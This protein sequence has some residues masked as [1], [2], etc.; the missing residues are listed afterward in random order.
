MLLSGLAVYRLSMLLYFLQRGDCFNGQ[1][2]IDFL[3]FIKLSV[4][5]LL[6]FLRMGGSLLQ[7]LLFLDLQ[8]LVLAR[9]VDQAT[10]PGQRSAKIALSLQ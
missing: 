9:S 7:I 5:L 4:A 10:R 8:L 2:S 1:L 6:A 3:K